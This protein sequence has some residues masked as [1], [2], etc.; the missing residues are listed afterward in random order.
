MSQHA[1]GVPLVDRRRR[2]RRVT[3]P[4]K[5]A[6]DA[7]V[8]RGLT[9]SEA[10]KL[11]G[12]TDHA[13]YCA[14]RKPHV[15]AY[16]REQL[17][18]LREGEAIRSIARIADLADGAASESVKFDANKYLLALEGTDPYTNKQ[19][20]NP[21]IGQVNLPGLTIVYNEQSQ[22]IEAEGDVIEG[23]VTSVPHPALNDE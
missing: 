9:R 8:E 16:R 2:N 17:K 22:A 19:S 7:I 10:A 18:V 1:L 23:K 11:A 21:S 15:L 14:L 6:I 20:N 13:L 5:A 4:V 12:I 3:K